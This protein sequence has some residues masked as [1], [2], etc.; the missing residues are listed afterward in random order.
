MPWTLPSRL[1]LR[2]CHAGFCKR[3]FAW[4]AGQGSSFRSWCARMRAPCTTCGRLLLRHSGN[5]L[6]LD[7]AERKRHL[8]CRLQLFW[9]SNRRAPPARVCRRRSPWPLSDRRTFLRA[10]CAPDRRRRTAFRRGWDCRR[11]RAEWL[12]RCENHAIGTVIP[13]VWPLTNSATLV[14]FFGSITYCCASNS[15][16]SHASTISGRAS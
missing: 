4:F 7:H 5:V 8:R 10:A 13:A 6:R 3:R 2:I 12:R 15:V 9:P 16:L 11:R 1:R 14:Q